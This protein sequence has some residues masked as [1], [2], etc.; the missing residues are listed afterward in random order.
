MNAVSKRIFDVILALIGFIFAGPIIALVSL[1]VW[2]D[3]PG[4]V[5][6]AQERLGLHGKRFWMF[7]FRKFPAHW[8]DEGP[9]VTTKQDP[10]MTRIG[11]VLERTKIDELPQFWNILK[12]EMSF[13]GPRPESMRFSDLFTGKYHDL[14]EYKP[15]IFG[16]CQTAFRNENS[17]Y[18]PD[19]DPERFYRRVLFPQKAEADLAYF[20]KASC[21]K[22]IVFIIKGTWVTITGLVNWR[23]FLSL[24][25]KTLALDLF[26]IA[27]AWTLA[28]IFRFEGLPPGL[29][30]I[31]MI[32]GLL[33][34]PALLLLGMV[35]AGCYKCPV[36]YFSLSNAT[37]LTF[38]ISFM[39]I[40]I[41]LLAIKFYRNLSLYLAPLVIIISSAFLV[42]HRGLARLRWE[43]SLGEKSDGTD[44][45]LIYGVGRTGLVLA[46]CFTNGKLIGFVD[47]DSHLRGNRIR[48]YK[49]FGHEN[50]IPTIHKVHNFNHLW[51]TF[52]IA[53]EKRM[54]LKK[55]CEDN[56]IK[57]LILPESEP[58][59]TLYS[60][61]L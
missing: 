46:S 21:L 32:K 25:V 14:L 18:T 58:F 59:T 33:Y 53:T 9:G 17:F 34:I 3:S 11:A 40:L 10:R 16:P 30:R 57:L 45:I 5:I 44:R 4:N 38:V 39:W 43:K 27:V 31:V 6:F 36:R 56:N 42:A 7:K 8:G 28:H 13:V 12:G 26:F 48:G 29:D 47:D 61:K 19:E 37:R 22:D 52:P 2:L 49:V 15:G 1:L 54:R 60:C 24:H 41:F 51:V 20:Q 50:A 35:A 55:F 23:Q